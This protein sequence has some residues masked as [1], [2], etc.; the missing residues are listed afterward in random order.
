MAM[1]GFTLRAHGYSL[2]S[3][4]G[5]DARAVLDV[6][7]N[8][9]DI[10]QF[11]KNLGLTDFKKK[12]VERIVIVV[13]SGMNDT[14]NGMSIPSTARARKALEINGPNTIYIPTARFTYRL[15]SFFSGRENEPISTDAREIAKFLVN[16]WVNHESIICEEWSNC[17]F[18]NA[19]FSR[20][21]TDAF[22]SP[23]VRL[24]VVTS[25]WARERAEI[26]FWLLFRGRNLDFVE[27]RGDLDGE[28]ESQ[29]RTQEHIVNE[30][31]YNPSI[32]HYG[33]DRGEDSLLSALWYLREINASTPGNKQDWFAIQT[34]LIVQ[35][36]GIVSGA[37]Y[38]LKGNKH[39]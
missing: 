14:Q 21:L 29:R 31:L 5:A 22:L 19:V 26:V 1:F 25:S 36:S 32:Q 3:E 11:Q 24:T 6:L 27:A 34:S 10:V 7:K 13:G 20:L 17:T 9:W 18:G 15:L 2:P 23:E 8:P 35:S 30:K 4:N 33:L 38:G 37:S 16:S 12:T 39:T 28:H